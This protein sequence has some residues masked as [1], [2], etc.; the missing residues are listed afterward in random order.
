ML[1]VFVVPQPFGVLR[2]WPFSH[3]R[4]LG[5]VETIGESPQRVKSGGVVWLFFHL[6]CLTAFVHTFCQSQAPVGD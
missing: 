4:Q 6:S 3:A 2:T 1:T 5:V